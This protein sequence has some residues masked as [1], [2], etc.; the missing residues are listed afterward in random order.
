MPSLHVALCFS[1]SIPLLSS[2]PCHYMVHLSTC[3]PPILLPLLPSFCLLVSPFVY[4]PLQHP[5]LLISVLDVLFVIIAIHQS[6]PLP[7]FYSRDKNS[8]FPNG[9]HTFTFLP[10][11]CQKLK[12]QISYEREKL[13]TASQKIITDR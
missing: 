9:W 2:T 1:L 13:H 6:L 7:L 12:L 8:V 11:G 4:L 5:S 3:H 10:D